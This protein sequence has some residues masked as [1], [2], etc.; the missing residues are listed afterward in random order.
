[1]SEVYFLPMSGNAEELSGSIERGDLYCWS[2]VDLHAVQEILGLQRNLVQ[3]SNSVFTISILLNMRPKILT[4]GVIYSS[5]R[6][7]D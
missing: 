3:S 4:K 1:M 5:S 6:Y 7:D 2:C